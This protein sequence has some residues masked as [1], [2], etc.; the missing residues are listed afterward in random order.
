MMQQICNVNRVNNI[1]YA[2][3][4]PVSAGK[5][6]FNNAL[7]TQT[8]SDMKRKKTTMLPQIYSTTNDKSVNI[9]TIDKIYERN[10]LSNDYVLSRRENS[11]FDYNTDFEEIHHTIDP[12]IDFVSLPD[13][14]S[15][16]SILDM[17][18]LN[19]GG[20]EMYYD[21]IK[22]VSHK[23]DIYFVL[24]DINSG[25]NTS[26]EIKIID[27]VVEQVTKNSHGYI[28]FLINKC[29]DLEFDSDGKVHFNDDELEELYNRSIETIGAKCKKIKDK[30]TVIPICSSKLYIYRG[31]KNNIG[32]IDE[33]QLDTIIKTTCG[34]RELKKINSIDKKRQFIQGLLNEK[35]KD[36][37]YEGWMEETG[38]HIFKEQLS[39]HINR[40]YSDYIFHHIAMELDIITS[41]YTNLCKT[42]DD[43]LY[44]AMTN[45][46]KIIDELIQSTLNYSKKNVVPDYVYSKLVH[47]NSLINDV[48]QI[49]TN[50][51]NEYNN[52]EMNLIDDVISTIDNYCKYFTKYCKN[53]FK[54]YQFI[55]N[56]KNQIMINQFVKKFDAVLYENVV[57]FVTHDQLAES[58]RGALNE[59]NEKN[60][61]VAFVVFCDIYHQLSNRMDHVVILFKI[62]D[63][64][65]G[66][67]NESY[68][69]LASSIKN[70]AGIYECGRCADLYFNQTF[71]INLN[72]LNF[73]QKLDVFRNLLSIFI[74]VGNS[75]IDDSLFNSYVLYRILFIDQ[76]DNKNKTIFDEWHKSKNI[77][78]RQLRYIYHSIHDDLMHVNYWFQILPNA[79]KTFLDFDKELNKFDTVHKWLEIF[80]NDYNITKKSTSDLYESDYSND[81]NNEEE[82]VSVDSLDENT[83]ENVYTEAMHNASLTASKILSLGQK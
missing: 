54:T 31:V 76:K 58:I 69:D 41:H 75:V 3:L 71:L 80:I 35:K 45:E 77:G 46:I 72:K 18:G 42:R 9:D 40:H 24:F 61:T 68:L 82:D 15:T 13:I 66:K 7:F 14:G 4:G 21:Y 6:T 62:F 74:I 78:S 2:I 26:D 57:E 25:L 79:H 38:Y 12:L 29:D 70:N 73:A 37:L 27:L 65:I 60:C 39:S 17:P 51:I 56:K 44:R 52:E 83:S 34:T 22:S 32:L 67:V 81:N 19:C 20:D 47:F 43:S 28:Y 63:S 49:A 23:L 50:N 5:S 64:E 11:T 1:S 8:C 55:T 36:N 53:V 59:S 48:C 10:K 16:Y 30:F 33:K